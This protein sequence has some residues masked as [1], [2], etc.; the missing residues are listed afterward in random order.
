VTVA[1]VAFGAVARFG[2]AGYA[3]TGEQAMSETGLGELYERYAPAI[4]AHCRR[5][6]SSPAAARDATQEAFVRVLAR[7]P[8]LPA[9]DDALRYLYRVSTNV[10]LNQLRERRVHERAA[11]ALVARSGGTPWASEGGHAD[12]QFVSALLARCDET[13]GAIAV[14]HYVDGMSQVEIADVL[15]ITRRTVFN[16]LRKLEK[17]ADELLRTAGDESERAKA[18]DKKREGTA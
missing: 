6:L 10:C 7:G 17:I 18:P 1:A 9:G 4:Y 12:R 2:N 8:S 16:R 14:M 5:L 15:G 13:G 11:P 3:G